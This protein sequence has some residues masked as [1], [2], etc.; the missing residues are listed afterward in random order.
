MF[1]FIVEETKNITNSFTAL[2][3]LDTPTHNVCICVQAG[4]KVHVYQVK[5]V[6]IYGDDI[7]TTWMNAKSLNPHVSL[8]NNLGVDELQDLNLV[9]VEDLVEEGIHPKRA[10]KMVAEFRQIASQ[11]KSAQ[12]MVEILFSPSPANT[13]KPSQWIS[14]HHLGKYSGLFDKLGVDE[15]QDLDL[16]DVDDLVEEGVNRNRA[17][18]LIEKFRRATS[19]VPAE[20]S[21]Q[22]HPRS[23][24]DRHDYFESKSN[25]NIHK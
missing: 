3:S 5:E 22:V 17:G 4:T 21:Q 13:R 19:K 23:Q 1:F 8:F 6:T 18:K 16:V 14:K 20:D 7:D 15:L 10:A 2:S 24:I 9:E 11:D 12:A 25:M